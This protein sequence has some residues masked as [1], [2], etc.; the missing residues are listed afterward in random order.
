M[1]LRAASCALFLAAVLG[2]HV[3]AR[4]NLSAP[5]LPPPTDTVVRV[6]SEPAL[7]AAIAGLTSHT[8]ILIAPG[9]YALTRSLVINRAVDDV[10]IRGASGNRD[11]V[12][13]R[14][15]GMAN[16]DF[17]HVEFGIWAGGGV[18][19]ITIADLTI[20]DFYFHSI[21]FNAG[22]EAPVI[23][24]VHL[25]D[26]GQQIIKVNPDGQGG[27]VDRGVLEYS[28]LEFT[29]AARDDYPK[30]ID[31]QGADGWVIRHN[32]FRNIVGPGGIMAGPSILAWRGT[33]NT[34][35][36]GNTFVNCSRGILFGAENTPTPSHSGGIIRNNFFYRGPLQPG[37]VGIH[38]ADSPGTKVLNN[39]VI[40]SGTYPYPIE[41]RFPDATGVVIA[42]NLTDGPIRQRD[43][44]QA[45]LRANYLL[46]KSSWFV[47]PAVGDLHLRVPALE[48]VGQAQYV[49]GVS[50][51]WDGE[52]RPRAGSDIGADQRQRP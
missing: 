50:D 40:L 30:G 13:I 17:G 21:I 28:L 16:A 14:G 38:V 47:N 36:E 25:I 26:A 12:V 45:Q 19:H 46:A 1:S 8:T 39:T 5:P 32:L 49:E 43:R 27:G 31:V 35:A 29:T 9:H 51:D 20:R 2:S 23:H 15:R 41:Y 44:A 11:D 22:A 7:Q 3:A 33:R 42:N 52:P 48:I 34:L 10:A 6:A 37:D 18:N 24:N 4:S